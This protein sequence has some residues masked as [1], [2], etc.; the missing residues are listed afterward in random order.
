M[1]NEYGVMAV[2]RVLNRNLQYIKEKIVRRLIWKYNITELSEDEFLNEV[3]YLF[4]INFYKYYEIDQQY[5]SMTYIFGRNFILT[6]KTEQKTKGKYV[7]KDLREVASRISFFSEED[8]GLNVIDNIPDTKNF[9]D[10]VHKQDIVN[11]LRSRVGKM[12]NLIIDYILDGCS[13]KKICEL[14]GISNT[15][16]LQRKSMM[17]KILVSI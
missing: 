15:T 5:L 13:V 14:L 11:V 4:F 12:E 8:N 10:R 7:I 6:L 17:R 2:Q 1:S 16:L 9:I 3:L